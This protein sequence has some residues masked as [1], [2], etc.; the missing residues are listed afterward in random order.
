MPG[1]RWFAAFYE[2][3][4]RREGVRI[5][6]MRQRIAGGAMGDVLEIGAGPGLDFPYYRPA[7]ARR[8][9]ATDPDPYMLRRAVEPGRG[10]VVPVHLSLAAAES[11]PFVDASF[12]TVVSVLVLCTVEDPIQALTEVRRVLRPGGTL[13]FLEH[14]RGDGMLGAVHDVIVPVWRWCAAGCHPNR[15]TADLLDAAGFEF[16]E[17]RRRRLT[18]GGPA[19]MGVARVRRN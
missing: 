18:P 5:R 8:V 3:I 17:F 12:D 7:L 2:F 6:R 15:R 9:A 16:A 4:G 13:R 19:I 1:H 10:A 14:V 11:L